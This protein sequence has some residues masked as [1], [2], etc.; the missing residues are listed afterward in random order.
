MEACLI[1]LSDN[2]QVSLKPMLAIK[3]SISMRVPS[4]LLLIWTS[5]PQCQFLGPQYCQSAAVY[6]LRFRINELKLD[7]ENC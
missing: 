5:V 3:L 6:L 4:F 1:G 2:W 7:G